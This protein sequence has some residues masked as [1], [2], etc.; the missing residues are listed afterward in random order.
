MRLTDI[1][2]SYSKRNT[3][4]HFL[5]PVLWSVLSKYL[6]CDATSQAFTLKIIQ[7][8][9]TDYSERAAFPIGRSY[10]ESSGPHT[11]HKTSHLSST[12]LTNHRVENQ[13]EKSG[14]WESAE[15]S[16]LCA[17]MHVCVAN[18][19]KSNRPLLCVTQCFKHHQFPVEQFPEEILVLVLAGGLSLLCSFLTHAHIHTHEHTHTLTHTHMQTCTH[20]LS[21]TLISSGVS[22]F[23]CNIQNPTFSLSTQTKQRDC[24]VKEE[25]NQIMGIRNVTCSKIT[26]NNHQMLKNLKNITQIFL[27]VTEQKI[28]DC[29]HVRN[30]IALIVIMIIIIIIK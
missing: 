8:L 4:N 20:S 19:L 9:N 30:K 3:Y 12:L 5:Q 14:N 16:W 1:I 17:C 26:I 13:H 23:Y 6:L 21:F 29:K 7:K 10:T 22:L 2:P 11:I 24:G 27:H 25:S 15:R 18:L 28:I